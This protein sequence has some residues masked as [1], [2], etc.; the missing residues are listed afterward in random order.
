MC[1]GVDKA[2]RQSP[3]QVGVGVAVAV[4]VDALSSQK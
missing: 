4:A 2:H 1:T 3:R